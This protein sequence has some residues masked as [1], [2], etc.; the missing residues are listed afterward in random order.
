VLHG[1]PI[2]QHET[3]MQ[4]LMALLSDRDVAR[5]RSFASRPSSSH[6]LAAVR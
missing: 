2:N 5:R 3:R 6:Q 4:A 1:H